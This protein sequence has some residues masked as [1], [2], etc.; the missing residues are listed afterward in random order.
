MKP[1]SGAGT[2]CYRVAAEERFCRNCSVVLHGKDWYMGVCSQCIV[3]AS[4]KRPTVPS[5][6]YGFGA[7]AR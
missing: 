3:E 7:Q 4:H 1:R 6:G 5:P 2:R